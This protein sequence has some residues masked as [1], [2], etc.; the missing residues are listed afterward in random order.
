MEIR[1]ISR[2]KTVVVIVLMF[3]AL[4]AAVF[5]GGNKASAY[6]VYDAGGETYSY[7]EGLKRNY[8]NN[9][10]RVSFEGIS[11]TY[12][13][14]EIEDYSG[15]RFYLDPNNKNS[16]YLVFQSPYTLDS[17]VG[18]NDGLLNE[19]SFLTYAGVI[20]KN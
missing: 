20:L 10:V 3:A 6:S 11:S 4:S 19:Y 5:A 13:P 17:L 7:D 16:G 18:F 2:K 12:A 1:N 9:A 15:A 8:V 14:E